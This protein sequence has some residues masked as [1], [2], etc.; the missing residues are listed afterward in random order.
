MGIDIRTATVLSGAKSLGADF[1]RSAMIGRLSLFED[2]GFSDIYALHRAAAPPPSEYSEPFLQALG[3][4]SVHSFDA[5]EYEGATHVH[6]FNLPI[7]DEL[8]ERYSLV[9]DGGTLEHVFN[10]PQ[11][12]R[13]CMEMLEVG[14]FFVS[15]GPCNNQMGHGFWQ[16]SPELAYRVFSPANGFETLGVF[17]QEADQNWWKEANGP[18]YFVRDPAEVG[19]RVTLRNCRT[20]F[21]HVIARRTAIKPIFDA[22]PQQSD[23]SAVWEQG[24]PRQSPSGFSPI[25]LAKVLTP[26]IL[27]RPFKPTFPAHFYQRV[28]DADVMRGKFARA[29]AN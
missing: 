12:F 4:D 19:E 29:L 27:K 26:A 5:S 7:P 22:I 24:A 14:G 3:A 6:D 20:T 16:F 17:V 23:Y 15:S 10:A 13:N 9:V 18:F 2:K 25:R 28:D 1:A 8:R 21:L 11:A